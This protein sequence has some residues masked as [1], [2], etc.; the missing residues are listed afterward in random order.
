MN[1]LTREDNRL[2]WLPRYRLAPTGQ[3][4]RVRHTRNCERSVPVSWTISSIA[5][6]L[7]NEGG[8][9]VRVE[10]GREDGGGR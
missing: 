8:G 1:S 4:R 6:D 5:A 3:P 7:R 10:E 2:K 9:V